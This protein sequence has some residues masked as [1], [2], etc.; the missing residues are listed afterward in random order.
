ME[1]TL[2]AALAKN[3]VIGVQG[4]LP[5]HLPADFQQFK[6]RTLGKPVIMGRKTWESLPRTPLPKRHN[7]V[8]TRQASYDAP[9]ATV[10]H[11]LNAAFEA[12]NTAPEV[13]ILGGAQLFAEALPRA[14]RMVL[15]HIEAEVAGDAVFPEVDWA[16]W[17]AVHEERHEAD[18]RHAHPFRVVV[19]ERARAGAPG[20]KNQAQRNA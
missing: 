19:Y 7:I 11:S 2:I 4:R 6:R 20:S 15:T 18:E 13:M 8:V 17:R 1:V 5:W 3:G 9:G 14:D 10:V 12:A 16:S